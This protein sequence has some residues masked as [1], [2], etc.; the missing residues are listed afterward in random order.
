MVGLNPAT[1]ESLEKSTMP[2]NV[3][4][5]IDAAFTDAVGMTDLPR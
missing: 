4:T 2:S 5:Q 1:G 3:N